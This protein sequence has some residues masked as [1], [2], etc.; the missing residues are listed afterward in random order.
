MDPDVGQAP[1]REL[2][3]LPTSPDPRDGHIA[4]P[5]QINNFPRTPASPDV[6][7]AAVPRNRAVLRRNHSVVPHVRHHILVDAL[8]QMHAA[9]VPHVD[10]SAA[11]AGHLQR[12]VVPHDL[13]RRD[14][15][16]QLDGAVVAHNQIGLALVAD[17]GQRQ[18]VPHVLL[19]ADRCAHFV[20][21]WVDATG[22]G[23]GWRRFKRR[24]LALWLFT[25]AKRGAVGSSCDP[26]GTTT[27]SVFCSIH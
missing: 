27:K 19:Q 6:P 26:W 14:V 2:R 22:A 11:P 12:A 7:V 17:Q 24:R 9:V 15:V 10:D 3:Q 1:S 25:G 5:I 23:S 18:V 4:L 16:G 21:G 8:V 13:D 20:R